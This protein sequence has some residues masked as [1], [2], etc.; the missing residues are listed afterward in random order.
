MNASIAPHILLI[1]DDPDT[2]FL[3]R[4]TLADHFGID[5]VV[6]VERI[7]QAL[8]QDLSTFDLVLS[9]INLPDGSGLDLIEQ[10]LALRRDLPIIMVTSESALDN[11]T[12]AIRRG[13]Y[14][15][16]VK[17]GDYLFTIPLI[18]EKNLA[19]W[20]IKVQN[21]HL[22]QELEQTLAELRIKN[23]QLEEA[24]NQLEQQAS[25]DPLTSLA[26]R[27]HMQSMLDRCFAEA[28]RYGTDLACLMMD[29]DSFKPFNDTLGHQMGDKLLQT[30]ARV[31]Q[32]NCRRCDVAG[33]Y[34]GDEFVLLLPHTSPNIAQQVARRIRQ[35]FIAAARSMFP[36]GLTC[37][38]SV[39]VA[40]VSTS[41]AA[42]ADQLVALADA[43]LYRAKQAGKARIHVYQS[44]GDQAVAD[45]PGDQSIAMADDAHHAPADSA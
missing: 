17:A 40:C 28:T 16:V 25:T 42:T 34:G 37:N 36:E 35:Q 38:V 44:Q 27:R 29:L 24:V 13:A 22:Q 26:N 18:V 12:L 39:G 9:D 20:Q 7:D 2:A 23:T 8:A 4:E 11:A 19:V 10:L 1:E 31:L 30:M 3:I 21:L 6:H 14:D 33:R 15:Y 41:R 45:E 32:A 43:A 5:H